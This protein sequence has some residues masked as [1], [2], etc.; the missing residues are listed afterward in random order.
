MVPGAV[1]STFS[2]SLQQLGIKVSGAG[3]SCGEAPAV[4]SHVLHVEADTN[5]VEGS[6]V[7]SCS[8]SFPVRMESCGRGGAHEGRL[9]SKKL[10]GKDNQYDEKRALAKLWKVLAAKY[11]AAPLE[12]F[13][14]SEFPLEQVS[15]A[16]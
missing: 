6:V 16:Q 12:S 2:A 15:A 10:R 3:A 1:E 9:E 13:L 5:C 11:L 14:A 8:M 4:P 7:L